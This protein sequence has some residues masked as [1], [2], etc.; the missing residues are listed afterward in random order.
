MF[1]KTLI[2]LTTLNAII[3]IS[4]IA[5]LGAALYLYTQ[6]VLYRSANHSLH[7][8]ENTFVNH[9][10]PFPG[11]G[12]TR[13]QMI[14]WDQNKEVAGT[15]RGVTLSESQLKKLYPKQNNKIEEKQIKEGF[16]KTLSIRAITPQGST[17]IEFYKDITVEKLL[18]NKLLIIIILG[19]LIGTV[20]AIGGGFF[21]ARRALKPIQNSWEKQQ[22]FVSDA[23][24]EMRTPLAIIQTKTELLLKHP[25]SRISES[26]K[27]ISVTL[28]ETRR[29][30]RMVSHLLTLARSDGNRIEIQRHPILMN[31]MLKQVAEYFEEMADY[32]EK[33]LRLSMTDEPVYILG[34]EERLHQLLVILLDNAMKFTEPG[35][36]IIVSGWVEN[37]MVYIKVRDTGIGINNEDIPKIFDRFFQSDLSR[38]ERE[39][40]GLGLSLAQ[41]IIE[42]HKGKISVESEI[43]KG[44]S[45]EAKFPLYKEK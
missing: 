13:I 6:N 21:L 9:N 7:N 14:F 30:S 17:V 5:V 18:L 38:E 34:D 22:Q 45:F 11:G 20:L 40:T 10:K 44:T 15:S 4:L 39:G 32:Q 28:K 3:F 41:W 8:A 35:D 25:H 16:Y 37:N 29:L 1:R 27:E 31:D 33:K 43:G 36:E 24:H 23:S 26:V 42:K 19:C 12:D 2:K